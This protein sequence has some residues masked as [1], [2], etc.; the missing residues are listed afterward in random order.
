[1]AAAAKYHALAASK[2]LSLAQLALAWCKSR[3]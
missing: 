2:G 1:M 3:W